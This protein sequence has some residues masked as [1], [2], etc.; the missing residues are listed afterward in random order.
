MRGRWVQVGLVIAVLLGINL[1]ARLIVRFALPD[2]DPY[3][4]GLLSLAGM[5]VVA[6]LAGFRWRRRYV[7]LRVLEDL[8]LAV[9]AGS[10]LVLLLG[11]LAAGYSPFGVGVGSWFALLGITALALA[12]GVFAGVFVAMAF[13]M[14]PTARGYR[15]AEQESARRA[16]RGRRV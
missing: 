13:G 2:E 4:A 15:R 8:A 16:Q 11:P 12:V 10:L 3:L 5:V 14:D 7:A 1:V 9:I 6:A